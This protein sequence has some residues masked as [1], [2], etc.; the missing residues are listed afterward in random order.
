MNHA[1]SARRGEENKDVRGAAAMKNTG[2][3]VGAALNSKN[4]EV[5]QCEDHVATM[6]SEDTMD[7]G[8]AWAGKNASWVPDEETGVFAP[9]D[10]DTAATHGPPGAAAAMPT[11]GGSVLDQAVFVREEEMEDV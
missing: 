5:L 8:G 11:A 6:L 2:E 1:T 3:Q 9:A 10:A 4:V 7:I